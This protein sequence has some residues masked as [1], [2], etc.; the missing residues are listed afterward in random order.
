MTDKTVEHPCTETNRALLTYD[1][2]HEMFALSIGPGDH[3][4]LR[5]RFVAVGAES[6]FM[7][8]LS[9][10]LDGKVN[11]T[12]FHVGAGPEVLDWVVRGCALAGYTLTVTADPGS[13]SGVN[14]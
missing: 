8:M 9:T 7:Q 2:E 6:G 1:R 10:L 11:V 14:R 4:G 5:S 3:E 13:V 12:A